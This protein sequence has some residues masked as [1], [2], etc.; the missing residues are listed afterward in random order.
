MEVIN[1]FWSQEICSLMTQLRAYVW[2]TNCVTRIEFDTG[3]ALGGFID[4]L[5]ASPRDRRVEQT[6]DLSNKRN[7][8]RMDGKSDHTG[9]ESKAKKR[10]DVQHSRRPSPRHLIGLRARSPCR[11]ALSCFDV[12]V[13]L[14][15]PS[16]LQRQRGL[17]RRLLCPVGGEWGQVRPLWGRLEC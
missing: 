16:Q 10:K 15:H 11:A 1:T 4:V 7:A 12:E 3:F 14:R 13:R 17:L 2:L 6:V 8:G 9:E 5:L